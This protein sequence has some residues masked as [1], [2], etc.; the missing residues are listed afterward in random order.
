ML[1]PLRFIYIKSDISTI[2][3][4]DAARIVQKIIPKLRL[5]MRK[6]RP[7]KIVCDNKQDRNY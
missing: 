2:K 7:K 3:P 5:Q 4:A 1:I 6:F